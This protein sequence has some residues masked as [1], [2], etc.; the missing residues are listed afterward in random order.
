MPQSTAKPRIYLLSV[1]LFVFLW[2]FAIYNFNFRGPDE[3][4]YFAYTASLV[5]DGDLNVVNH[6]WPTQ[7]IEVSSTYNSPDFH[8]HGG[9]IIWAPFYIYAK[10]VYRFLSL[11]SPYANKPVSL[12]QVLGGLLSLSTVIVGFLTI[13]FT[14][15]FSRRFFSRS[16][17]LFATFTVFF[18]TPFFYYMLFEPANANILAAFFSILSLWFCIYAVGMKKHYAFLYG[19]FFSICIV[20]KADLWFQGFFIFA[21]FLFLAFHKR[22]SWSWGIYFISGI[23][24]GVLLKIINDYVKYGVFRVGELGLFS[25]KSLLHLEQLFS[26]YRGYLYTSPILYIC[27]LG[28]LLLLINSYSKIKR[29][30]SPLTESDAYLLILSFYLIIKVISL[31]FG[32]AWGGGTVGARNLLTEFPVFVL[33]FGRFLN[34]Q[35]KLVRRTLFVLSFLFIAWNLIVISEFIAG[36]DLRYMVQPPV[37]LARIKMLAHIFPLLSIPQSLSLKFFYSW[38][39]LLIILAVTG[40]LLARDKEPRDTKTVTLCTWGSLPQAGARGL[41]LLGILTVYALSAYCIITLLNVYNNPRKV[42]RLRAEGFLN[43]A[44]ILNSRDFERSENSG[45]LDEMIAYFQAKGDTHRVD[46]IQIY[47]NQLYG[48]TDGMGQ[49]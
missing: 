44:V 19:V 4:I 30:V 3:P 28:V 46:R 24:P 32:Y 25:G 48:Q 39:L 22:I 40:Y 7:Q 17:A 23:I 31:G 16:L 29:N 14:Y 38:P 27:F 15:I 18:G 37:L 2:F 9:V 26:S 8:N 41:S 42:S 43:S 21:A 6:L 45:S 36:V 33:L 1:F 13:L 49:D 12:D 35:S 5:Q 20:I 10:T 11:L 34:G 47:K